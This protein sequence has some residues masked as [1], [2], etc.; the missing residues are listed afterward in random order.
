M[1]TYGGADV[2]SHVFFTL[3]L[4]G[5]QWSASRHGRFTSGE[6]T[7]DNHWKGGWLGPR[8]GL[9]VENRK[10]LTLPGLELKHLGRT[11]VSQSL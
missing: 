9:D 2:Q 4:V 11:A 3:A 6:R 5:V 8:T 10:F 7:N 1:K